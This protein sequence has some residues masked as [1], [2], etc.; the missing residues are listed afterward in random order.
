MSA[1]HQL[2]EFDRQPQR[3]PDP[4]L[5]RIVIGPALGATIGLTASVLLVAAVTLV[6]V[7]LSIWALLGIPVVGVILGAIVGMLLSV[8]GRSHQDA[9]VRDRRL[10]GRRRAATSENPEGSAGGDRPV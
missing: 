3:G 10:L 7:G 9:P 2:I 1:P 8:A 6:F 5:T 4:E